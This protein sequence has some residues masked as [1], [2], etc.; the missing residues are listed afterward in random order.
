MRKVYPEEQHK[1]H[2]TYSKT[3][4]KYCLDLTFKH[5]FIKVY[6]VLQKL[7][8]IYRIEANLT[9]CIMAWI[10]LKLH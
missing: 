5:L 6:Q 3:N 9:I 8:H 1:K 7:P 10:G 2:W 4:L